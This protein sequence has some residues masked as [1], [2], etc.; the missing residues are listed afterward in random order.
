MNIL[1]AVHNLFCHDIA[2][3]IVK[4]KYLQPKTHSYQVN[5]HFGVKVISAA[6]ELG[7]VTANSLGVLLKKIQK[8]HNLKLEQIVLTFQ[9]EN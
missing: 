6:G 9:P 8:H 5:L 4:P 7:V 1:T 2:D 3:K